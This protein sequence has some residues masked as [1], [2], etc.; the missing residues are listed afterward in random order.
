[1]PGV[2]LAAVRRL[3]A[4]VATFLEAHLGALPWGIPA[5]EVDPALAFAG[6]SEPG[7]IILREETLASPDTT[8]RLLTL[9][10]ECA[11]QYWGLL[12][13]GVPFLKE[14][15][16]ELWALRAVEALGAPGSLEPMLRLARGRLA[17]ALLR[18]GV[19][20]E[21]RWLGR[22]V[23]AVHALWRRE[24]SAL[25]D[26]LRGV[27]DLARSDR[28]DRVNV[29]SSFGRYGTLLQRWA[30][31]TEL[32]LPRLVQGRVVDALET[33]LETSVAIETAR[34]EHLE[35]W[36]GQSLETSGS[37]WIS[38]RQWSPVLA[39]NLAADREHYHRMAEGSALTRRRTRAGS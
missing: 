8:Y 37:A 36:I 1:V 26:T 5:I 2:S 9:A 22:D 10:H 19:Q 4:E 13:A 6:V 31:S 15:L 39:G 12:L 23:L 7:R 24:G 25:D 34:G 3:L 38:E 35:V 33:G 30:A 28:L 16:A 11:H 21:R 18:P 20:D 17:W 29:W 27:V 32:P 14:P